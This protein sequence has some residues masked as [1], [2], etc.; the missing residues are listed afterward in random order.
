[1]LIG[2]GKVGSCCVFFFR[3]SYAFLNPLRTFM[4]PCC[5]SATALCADKVGALAF[6]GFVFTTT[7]PTLCFSLALVSS[8]TVFIAVEALGD[9]KLG[10]IPFSREYVGCDGETTSD[11]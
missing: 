7:L 2:T 10:C 8:V 11:I 5:V 6:V 9:G 4:P 1:L 3:K